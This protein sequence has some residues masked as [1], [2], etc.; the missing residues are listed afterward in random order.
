MVPEQQEGNCTTASSHGFLVSEYSA[1]CACGEKAEWTGL[2]S[3]LAEGIQVSSISDTCVTNSDLRKLFFLNF[4]APYCEH[5]LPCELSEDC[6]QHSSHTCTV[7]G[8]GLSGVFKCFY[9]VC[10]L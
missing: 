8:Y 6:K 9:S 5:F 2:F 4:T 1:A 7:A 10:L 3:D